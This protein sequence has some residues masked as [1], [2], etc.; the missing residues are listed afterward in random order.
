MPDKMPG[1]PLAFIP[2]ETLESVLALFWKQGYAG[3]SLDDLERATRLARSSLYNTFGSKRDL[4][5]E[6]LRRYFARL[7]ESM[8]RPLE[9]GT[10][11]LADV[12]AFFKRLA[13]G[14]PKQLDAPDSLRGCLL[15][16][17]MVE[18]G[19]DDAEFQQAAHRFQERFTEAM[20]AALTRSATLGE[21]PRATVA[22]RTRLMLA[23][24][25]GINVA[26]RSGAP[27]NEI[28]ALCDAAIKEVRGWKAPPQASRRASAR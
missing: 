22:P 23:I 10:K 12:E 11:G 8:F 4:Y 21:I 28:R 24:A 20:T 26:S 1:R 13:E 6:S 15:V 9:E 16:N 5:L 7:A 19:D 2:D 27:E 18:F 17:A 25:L 3:T 14:L